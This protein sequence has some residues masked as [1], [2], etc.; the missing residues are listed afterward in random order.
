MLSLAQDF[1]IS[2]IIHPYLALFIAI[3]FETIATSSLKKS[4]QFSQLIPS[5]I[6]ILGYAGAFYFLSIALKTVPVGIAYAIWSAVGMILITIVGI[7]FFQQK[8]DLPAIIG[9]TLIIIGVI[10]LQVFS[11]MTIH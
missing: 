7:I 4:E 3:I 5:I 1:F 2:M 8:P 11:K 10:V 6:T 9:L